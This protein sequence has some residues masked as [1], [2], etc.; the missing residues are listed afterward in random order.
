MTIRPKCLRLADVRELLERRPPEVVLRGA[1]DSYCRRSPSEA[2][3]LFFLALRTV[4]PRVHLEV[5]SAL[6]TL[7]LFAVP[8]D[9][10]TVPRDAILDLTELWRYP[11]LHQDRVLSLLTKREYLTALEFEALGLGKRR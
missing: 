1:L 6:G 7:L 8:P 10:R 11:R 5:P 3:A 4:Q 9:L 2:F